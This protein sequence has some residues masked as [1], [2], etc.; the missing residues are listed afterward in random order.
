MANIVSKIILRRGST[1]H[2]SQVVLEDGEPGWDNDLNELYVGNGSVSGGI[3]VSID[4]DTNSFTI[5]NDGK[6]STKNILQYAPIT[7]P[8]SIV[9]TGSIKC[10][11]LDCDSI[12][13]GGLTTSTDI[14]IDSIT[15]T[16][17]KVL[18]STA[19]EGD[20]L[21]ITAP[22]T[23]SK[24]TTFNKSLYITE[25]V[26]CRSVA[27]DII[28]DRNNLGISL[29]ADNTG[30]PGLAITNKD[31]L[32]AT[33]T[34]DSDKDAL[35]LYSNTAIPGGDG[36]LC[37]N[38]PN[39]L[40]SASFDY[41]ACYNKDYTGSLYDSPFKVNNN[42]V[43]ISNR[44]N[45]NIL[46][47]N[48]LLSGSTSSAINLTYLNDDS[49]NDDLAGAKAFSVKDNN[50]Y[51][52]FYIKPI[53]EMALYSYAGS[54]AKIEI[55]TKGSGDSYI[56]HNVDSAGSDQKFI[57]TGAFVDGIDTTFQVQVLSGDEELAYSVKVDAT[58]GNMYPGTSGQDLGL[59]SAKWDNVYCNTLNAAS[60]ATGTFYGSGGELVTIV[61]GMITSIV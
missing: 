15:L 17:L 51:D 14:E 30:N 34:T 7:R 20:E 22:S 25:A 41:I 54:A 37:I 44:T 3:P 28:I 42:G 16:N 40:S 46:T 29:S 8:K 31:G 2:R 45:S 50:N 59:P 23:F 56:S 39:A 5:F 18:S 33:I 55:N 35:K 6:P 43:T 36:I 13:T 52:L 60:G 9:A 49:T 21:T 27:T 4:V 58:S 12:T 26:N 1:T 47:L 48:N 38:A 32:G 53:G 10:T 11:S 61:A 19:I 57:R 24:D